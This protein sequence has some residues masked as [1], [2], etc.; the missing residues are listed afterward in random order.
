MERMYEDESWGLDEVNVQ[1]ADL[2]EQLR[3]QSVE[4][5]YYEFIDAILAAFND[6]E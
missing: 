5:A 1:L 2:S 3:D 6:W 4:E